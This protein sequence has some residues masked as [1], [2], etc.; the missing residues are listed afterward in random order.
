MKLLLSI[1]L[2]LQMILNAAPLNILTTILL[3]PFW[4]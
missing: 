1:L 2:A 3:M 4:S